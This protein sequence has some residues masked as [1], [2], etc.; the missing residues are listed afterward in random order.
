MTS[1]NVRR[2][3]L[4]V[5]D[6]IVNLRLLDRIFCR[7]YTVEEARD[8]VEALQKLQSVPGISAVIL[9]ISMPVLD[10][11]GVL[12]SMREN[13]KLRS[14]PVIVDTASGD[15]ESQLKALELGAFDVLVKPISPR[16]A[17]QRVRNAIMRLE[18][19]KQTERSMMLEE[20]LRLSE[21]DEK[22]GIYNRQAFCRKTAALLSAN[23]EKEYVLLRTDVDRFKVI[24]DAYGIAKGDS[25]LA[26]VGA[27]YRKAG[28]PGMTYGHWE[29]DHFVSCIERDR[30]DPENVLKRISNF[31]EGFFQGFK[32]VA[33]LGVY[34]I[35]D[36]S[37]DVSLMCDRAMLALRSVKYSYVRQIAYYDESMRRSLIEEQEMAGEMEAAL[38]GGQF[39][40][41]FQPQYNY[42]EGTL[43]GAEALVRWRHP[44]KG[45]IPPDKFIPAFERNGF[46]MKLD[47]YV[48]EETCRLIRRWLDAGI[49]VV[50]L[51]VNISRRDIYRTD[52]A[53]HITELV[54]KYG[55]K[56]AQLRLEITESAYMENPEQLISVVNAFHKAGFSV[57]MD[58]FGSG[59]SSLNTLKDVPVDTLKLDMKF[60]VRSSDTGRGGN[61]L[62]SIVRMAHWLR[63]PVIAEGVETKEQ[64]EFLKSISCL[65]MQGYFFAKPMPEDE[66]ERLLKAGTPDINSGRRFAGDVAGALD[67][68]S[69]S[70]QS[71]LLFNTFV[72]GAAILEYD[73]VHFQALRINDRFFEILGVGR[74]EFAPYQL[75]VLSMFDEENRASC[76]AH[77]KE[78][79][80]SGDEE[81]F[82]TRL[83]SLREGHAELWTLNRIR[84]LVESAGTYIFFLS[85]DNITE[86]KQSIERLRVAE[87]RLKKIVESIPIGV[88]IFKLTDRIYPVFVSDRACEIFGFTREEYDKRIAENDPI[89]FAPTV[90]ELV[91]K[92]G[93]SF[94]SGAPVLIP[95]MLAARRDSTGFYLRIY[96][97]ASKEP[98]G[99][100]L[101]YA[102]LSDVSADV[103]NEH[104]ETWQSER[105]RLMSEAPG[106][107]TFDY[108][109]RNDELNLSITS[110]DKVHKNMRFEHYLGKFGAH[111]GAIAPESTGTYAAEFRRALADPARGSFIFKADLYG[112][113]YRF[114]QADYVGVADENDAVYRIVGRVDDVNDAVTEKLRLAASSRQDASVGLY[115]KAYALSVIEDILASKPPERFDALLF[116]DIDSFKRINDVYGHLEGDKAL[117]A[118]ALT[119]KNTFRA[120]DVIARFG[121]DEFLI[122]MP[123]AGCV[124][125]VKKKAEDV[126]SA[127]G[128]IP[129]GGFTP[130]RCSIGVA[131]VCDGETSLEG[132]LRMADKALYKAKSEGKNRCSVAD[133]AR[134][135]GIA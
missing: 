98:D 15:E 86:Q 54:K 100:V 126:I 124:S 90:A 28:V 18:A 95:R 36:P 88:A 115:N 72:G 24:N 128:A 51:S 92:Y 12:R 21:I 40:V 70:T 49:R 66:F 20:Q 62:T 96:F 32:C 112:T 53:E 83:L 45:L 87:E 76:V 121:G 93:D 7:E 79:I 77:I 2:T 46:I 19:V 17:M 39:T 103:K 23:P 113:G 16:L 11:Y 78:A 48:W 132:L 4:I 6:S 68:L 117:K 47:E 34:V 31:V 64:A 67:F 135:G 119:L 81:V 108:D 130:I 59:Y 29:A 52:L 3:I 106:A 69:D 38:S 13:D 5:D 57:E 8:G 80:A 35:D 42:S 65:Y 101:C 61:I 105:F 129:L 50:P 94:G 120:N 134:Y 44:V 58:D 82:E 89:V 123:S 30:F 33:R 27:E 109:P 104:K 25:F 26:A 116:I 9:D 97:T 85:T 60:L 41:Y 43:H 127:V 71:A 125:D 99:S 55:L 1:E 133:G 22:T 75:D 56:P 102:A 91:K 111:P 14:I 63:L 10:G 107:I 37:L 114:Y 74:E 110:Q 73:G 131:C 118:I 84:V 122:Y